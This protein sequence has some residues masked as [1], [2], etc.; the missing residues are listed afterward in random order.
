MEKFALEIITP[1]RKFFAGQVESITVKALSGNMQIL[2]KH[3]PV[4]AGLLPWVIKVK[5]EG[6][7]KFAVI[8]GGFLEFVDN[9]AMILADSAEWPEE[10]DTKR[11]E[12][13]LDRAKRRL[14]ASE[15]N[16]DKKR[17]KM[18]LLRAVE[19]LKASEIKGSK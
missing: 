6:A 18:A 4:A 17:A 10:I 2:A 5:Q 19:R 11:A 9:R 1:E 13:A 15:E 16:I 12:E 3:I 7:N 14:E 8:S